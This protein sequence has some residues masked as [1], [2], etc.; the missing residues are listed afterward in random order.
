MPPAPQLTRFFRFVIVS[1]FG[2]VT[3][4]T[5]FL[6]P[7]S[8]QK[9]EPSTD[10]LQSGPRRT[11]PKQ[12]SP[13]ISAPPRIATELRSKALETENLDVFIVLREQPHRE[14]AQQVDQLYQDRFQLAEEQYLAAANRRSVAGEDLQLAKKNLD[15]LIVEKRQELRRNLA[16]VLRPQQER[17]TADL[18]AMG[19]SN[20][21]SYLMINMLHAVVPSS[22]LNKLDADE[23]IAEVF[24]VSIHRAHLNISV[25]TFGAPSFWNA[26]ITGVNQSVAVLDTGLKSNHPALRPT[27]LF[28]AVFLTNGI[29]NPCFSDDLTPIDNVGHGTHVAGIVMS[30]GSSGW[31]NHQGVA[32]GLTSFYNLKI[33]FKCPQPGQPN[34]GSSDS[35]DVLA[36]FDWA[37]QNTPVTIFNY[38]FG[39]PVDGDDDGLTRMIDL[40]SDTFGLTIV[41]SAGND[42]PD[43]Q[44]I[45]SPG[46]GYNILSVANMDDKDT[47]SRSDDSVDST[48][49]R[50]PTVGQRFKPDI[51]TPGT[52]I[53]SAAYDWDGG[54]LGLNPDFVSK[55]GTSMA[56]PHITGAAAL[57]NNGGV[58]NALAKKAV[59]LNSTDT[60]GWTADKGWGYA[61]LAKS[62]QTPSAV[63]TIQPRG[64]ANSFF[65]YRS[66]GAIPSGAAATLTWN[67]HFFNGTPFFND[68][69]LYLYNR[70]GTELDSSETAIQNVEQ[71]SVTSS[72]SVVV[73]V[74]AFSTSFG[75]GAGLEVCALALPPATFIP[76]IGPLLSVSCAPPSSVAANS[77]FSVTCTVRNNGDLEAFNVLTSLTVPAGFNGGSTQNFGTVAPA[78]QV[79]RTWTI[80]S[81]TTAGTFQVS[82][83][84]SSY[85]ESFSAGT[86]FSV[87]PCR[88][89]GTFSLVAPS[90]GQILSPTNSVTLTW[91]SS[92]NAS[93]YDVFF[94]TS[95]NPPFVGNQI[96]TSRAVTVTA[97]Q[98][99]FW[100]VVARVNCGS[101]TTTAGVRSFSVQQAV[102]GGGSVRFSS[103]AYS[104]NENAGTA[105]ITVTRSGGTQTGTIQY[106]TSN[107]TAT[108][109]SDYTQTSGLLVFGTNETSKSFTVSIVN[110][111]AIEGSESVNIRLQSA[112]LSFTLGSPSSAVLTI[113]D[114]DVLL[115][116]TARPASNVTSNT[117]TASWNSAPGAAGYRLDVSTNSSFTSFVSGYQN[118]DVG[119]AL[120]R[121][122]SGLTASTPYHYRVRAYSGAITTANSNA[123]ALT[124]AGPII[125]IEQGTNNLAA[126]LDSVTWQR[127]PFSVLNLFNFS[128][129]R[130]TRVVLFTSDL[131]LTQPNSSQL[132]V[133]AGGRMLTVESVGP[134]MGVAGT[135]ASYIIVRLPDGLPTGNLPLLITL[136]GF[137]SVNSP[138]LGILP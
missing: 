79:S 34:S 54:F 4:L 108:A 123:V 69:D 134:A 128:A 26:S 81:G 19:A 101:A 107:G 52:D 39:G 31:A 61:N 22:A 113:V 127:G 14:L 87:T 51:A 85:G 10:F 30:Q 78:A 73:K 98:T 119:N 2:L 36:A 115:P 72:T 47:L 44:T 21:Q 33:G 121:T 45:T 92:A 91:L 118:L 35:A 77:N 94:G 71:V 90:N 82:S 88:A 18:R 27:N 125:F 112:S 93:S 60:H 76:S 49:S 65:F 131:G 104:V 133:Q 110:D 48:S 126:A 66:S 95:S 20:I 64:Q 28:N 114:N 103:S 124:T 41:V 53:L 56:A 106:V 68:L 132:I 120:N 5:M 100:R 130:H 84:S 50:G 97:G 59:L 29:G 122:V 42:G 55:T 15:D 3:L 70:L 58:L 111:S 138:L 135:S 11:T 7:T 37:L 109:G 67:R 83:S 24:P 12:S 96:G 86:S 62:F 75:G 25:P 6:T 23:L 102:G 105:T 99:Y 13:H 1:C 9:A 32:K 89:P 80:T 116:P 16:A 38:S 17:L 63:N 137:Q 136:R 129:D 43:S 117:F 57:L 8:S 46:L 40:L 74:K